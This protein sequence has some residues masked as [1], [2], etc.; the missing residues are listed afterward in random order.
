MNFTYWYGN[1]ENVSMFTVIYEGKPFDQ[2]TLKFSSHSGAPV[3]LTSS[4]N[5]STA[6]R[7]ILRSCTE[8]LCLK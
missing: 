3:N 7:T 2:L 6:V 8:V 5:A 1:T 4:I